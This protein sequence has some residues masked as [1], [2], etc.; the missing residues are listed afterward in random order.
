MQIENYRKLMQKAIQHLEEEF[1][2]LQLG[3]AST[4]LV[5]GIDVFV[6]AYGMKQKLSTLGNVA[7]LDAQ[8][9]KIEPWDKSV[10][11][12]IEKGIF[13]SGTGLTPMNHWDHILIRIPALTK[14][15]RE[16]LKKFVAK[17]GEDAKISLRNIRQDANKE[18][19]TEFDAKAISEDQKKVSEKQV[20]DLTKEF[21]TKIDTEVK[22]KSEDIMKV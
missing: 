19:K 17:L 8:T 11:S 13:E 20:D 18:I 12:S 6:A 10:L 2:R 4:G 16:E 21:T 9:I 22:N 14:E 5:E 15:R 1:S 7:I 3:R